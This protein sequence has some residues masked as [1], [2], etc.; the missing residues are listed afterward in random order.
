[1]VAKDRA[2]HFL[3]DVKSFDRV[4]GADQLA[5]LDRNNFGMVRC[6]VEGTL[7]YSKRIW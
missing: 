6:R 3:Y 2:A 4:L 7:N 1:V 5:E